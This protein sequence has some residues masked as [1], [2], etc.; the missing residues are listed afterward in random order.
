MVLPLWEAIDP[1]TADLEEVLARLRTAE[2]SADRA[3]VARLLREGHH[4]ILQRPA[5]RELI[6]AF[7]IDESKVLGRHDNIGRAAILEAVEGLLEPTDPRRV[8]AARERVRILERHHYW[9]AAWA[10]S[11]RLWQRLRDPRVRW[12]DADD[13]RVAV[14]RALVR[15]T[16]LAAKYASVSPEDAPADLSAM[17]RRAGRVLDEVG[18][19]GRVREWRILAQ[20]RELQARWAAKNRDRL[21]GLPARWEEEELAAIEAIDRSAA[22]L[23]VPRRMLAWHN[24]KLNVLLT[25]DR[26]ADFQRAVDD[27]LPELVARG[28]T[29]PSEVCAAHHTLELALR[30]RSKRW[31]PLREELA[32]WLAKLPAHTDETLRNP[33]AIPRHLVVNGVCIG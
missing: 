3:G 33:Y 8:D 15:Q 22:G 17:A 24:Q 25:A 32:A 2:P 28:E 23:E 1:E 16:S 21:L 5:D 10:W 7:L 18:D 20:R 30:R 4:H 12:A 31:L 11:H 27:F 29:W 19:P 14:A 26:P 13:K 6:C 9:A